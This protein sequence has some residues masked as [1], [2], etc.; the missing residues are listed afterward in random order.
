MLKRYTRY[1]LLV[2]LLAV[3]GFTGLYY[4]QEWM[5]M[6]HTPLPQDH[7]Y[8][9]KQTHQELFF[10]MPDGA[11]INALYFTVP[12]PKGAVLYVHGRGGNL[13]KPWAAVENEFT[14]RGYNCLIF[15]YRGF[16]K[17][18]GDVSEKQ[19]LSDTLYAYDFLK[20][21]FPQNEIVVYGCS[22][23]TGPATY[24][25][26]QRN[27]KLL[28]L[29]APYYS[30]L[31]LIPRSGY[32]IPAWLLQIILKF[33]LPTNKWMENVHSPVYIFHGKKDELIP[34][35]SSERLLRHVPHTTKATLITL[36]NGKH[37]YLP[38]HPVYQRTLDS[39]LD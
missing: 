26:S 39:L 20:E 4:N 23:G 25:A 12:N 34:Y 17:S 7:V 31:D 29:E 1:I 9:F 10:T 27:P 36:K 3:G 14:K 21:R 35:N 2:I 5:I 16:G 19:F 13:D 22:F 6:R 33:P 38:K 37:N 18:S 30:M 32:M 24:V 28:I 8:S 15:D 11:K